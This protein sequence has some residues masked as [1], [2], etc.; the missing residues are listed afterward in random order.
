M[1]LH[2]NP[3][4]SNEFGA[5]RCVAKNSLGDTDGTIKLYSK[6]NNAPLKIASSTIIQFFDKLFLAYFRQV[7]INLFASRVIYFLGIPS[8][9][10]NYVDN[11][12]NNRYKGKK[13]VKSSELYQQSKATGAE[14]EEP[15]NPG[16]RKGIQP[17]HKDSK[18]P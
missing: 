13:R 5:Y 1:R 3:L 18:N 10:V 14:G 6:N 12:D 15:E 16:K 4:T 2:I 11:Y 8:N 17:H 7:L 9:T